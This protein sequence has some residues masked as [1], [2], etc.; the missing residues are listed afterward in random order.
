MYVKRNK[1][2]HLLML[3]YLYYFYIKLY[4]MNLPCSGLPFSIKIFRHSDHPS[5]YTA[6]KDIPQASLGEDTAFS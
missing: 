6:C 3:M 2:F 4:G 1:F 5:T